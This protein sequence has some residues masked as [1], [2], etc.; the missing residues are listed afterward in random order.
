MKM[1]TLKLV[2]GIAC[3]ACLLSTLAGASVPL[4]G[5]PPVPAET[6]GSSVTQLL[7]RWTTFD[8]DT[9]KPQAIVA[10][11][12]NSRGIHG[13]IE[14]LL[15]ATGDGAPKCAKCTG[16]L[17]EKPILGLR[18]L[19]DMTQDGDDWSGKILDPESGKVYRCNVT[20]IDG[21]KRLKVRAYVGAAL[22]GRTQY[23]TRSP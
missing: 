22:F 14:K 11:Q 21:G 5:S 16:S 10:I 9:G 15:A 18:I 13:Q 19:W 17:K 7:G 2:L 23:W 3:A 1:G 8:D 4:G 20:I 12:Q 6:H